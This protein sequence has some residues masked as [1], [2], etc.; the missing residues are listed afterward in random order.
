MELE[1]SVESLN[2]GKQH[3]SSQIETANT[4]KS[5]IE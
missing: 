3:I 2:T 4:K 5:V 1:E